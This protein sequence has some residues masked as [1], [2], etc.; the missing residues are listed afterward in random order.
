MAVFDKLPPPPIFQALFELYQVEHP[1]LANDN[2]AN[3][4]GAARLPPMDASVDCLSAE[5][6]VRLPGLIDVHVHMREPGGEHK[7]TWESGTRAAVAGGITMVNKKL[8]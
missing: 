3:I 5:S 4:N 8:K 7:E 1:I 2:N 6:L